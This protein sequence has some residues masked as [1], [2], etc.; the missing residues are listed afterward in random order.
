MTVKNAF[1]FYVKSLSSIYETREAENISYWVFEDKIKMNRTAFPI[2][3]NDD[4]PELKANQLAYSLLRLMQGEPVQYVLGYSYFFGLKLKVSK[5][6]LI[7][8]PE[9][10]EL[11]EWILKDSSLENDKKG[12]RILDIATGSGCIAI[13][14]KLADPSFQVVATDLSEKALRI[15]KENA[16][17]CGAQI[18]FI[19]HDILS[20]EWNFPFSDFDVI[21]SNPPYVTDSEKNAMHKNILNFEPPEALFVP[22]HDPLIFYKSILRFVRTHLTPKGKIFLEINEKFAEEI[23]KLL[24]KEN[25]QSIVKKDMDDK[26]RMICATHVIFED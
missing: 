4:I 3:G 5:S 10:E 22:D 1:D 14:L 17:E 26:Y 9:T 19:Q 21:V 13:A 15:A 25:F 2:H 8:R 7:P 23:K 16:E 11:V 24:I 20:E 18:N 12:L 6:V